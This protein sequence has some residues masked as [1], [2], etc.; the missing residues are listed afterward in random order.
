MRRVATYVRL[1]ALDPACMR[2]Q[3]ERNPP[4][5]PS[6]PAIGDLCAHGAF[7]PPLALRRPARVAA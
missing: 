7:N 6:P 5:E 2:G 1:A 4:T 3:A